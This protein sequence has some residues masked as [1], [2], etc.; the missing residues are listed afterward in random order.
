VITSF[1]SEWVKFLRPGQ[2]IG[3]WGTMA[4]FAI[5]LTAILVLNAS[6]DVDTT[7]PT[8]P[9]EAGPVI[10]AAL[11]EAPGGLVFTFEAVGQL[12]G[13]IAL[14]IAASNLAT[15][16]T[17]GTLKMLLV[18]K[19]RRGVLISGKVVAVAAFVTI[20]VTLTLLVSAGLS[21][22]LASA[23]GIDTSQWWTA[24]GLTAAAQ[25]YAN[26]TLAAWVWGL[27]G[28]M[29][30]ALF[31]SGFPAIGVGIAYP[32]VVEGL[33]RLALPDVVKWM[34]GAALGAFTAGDAATALGTPPGL[35]YPV[36]AVLVAAYALVFL[37]VP[38][39]LVLRRDV[40]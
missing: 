27:M 10:P 5:L 36:A 25:A 11:L 39:A 24:E 23:R 16:Y 29:L 15:E 6:R 33:L 32:L 38:I 34:P 7:Q 17:A 19:P 4:G 31:R 9:G 28:T 35:D 8:R 18:R 3:S 2:L 37:A 1:R 12:L 30:A 22:A 21:V 26:V 40:A 13:I 20:G 14:V